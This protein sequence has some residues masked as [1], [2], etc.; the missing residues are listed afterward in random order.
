MVGGMVVVS[1]D[2]L[3]ER[4]RFLQNAAGAVPGPWDCWLA[5]RG[6]KTL[7][8]RMRAHNENGQRI[9]EWLEGTEVERSTT[10]AS[11]RTRSTSWRGGR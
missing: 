11:R 2:E 6:T 7:H 8:L 9:A 3:H 4:L 10:R 1:D 5:L